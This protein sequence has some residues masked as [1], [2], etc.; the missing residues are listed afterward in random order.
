MTTLKRSV[1]VLLSILMVFS[2]MAAGFTV[3]SAATSTTVYFVDSW[4]WGEVRCYGYNDSASDGTFPGNNMT[5]VDTVDGYDVYSYDVTVYTTISFNNG[6]VYNKTGNLSASDLYGKYYEPSTG[7]TYSSAKEAL[8]AAGLVEGTKFESGSTVY[9]QPAC[10]NSYGAR[11]AA[12]FYNLNGGS[13]WADLTVMSN[14][15]SVYSVT[16]P[17]G[18]WTNVIF[19]RMN[20][21]NGNNTWDNVWNQTANLM[22]D[23]VNNCY[24]ISDWDAG[25][26]KTYTEKVVYF[27][28]AIGWDTVNGYGTTDG[29][30]SNTAW[31]GK[32]ATLVDSEN[33][34]YSFN[35]GDRKKVLFNDNDANGEYTSY[36]TCEDVYGQYIEAKTNAVYETAEEAWAAANALN[37]PSTDVVNFTVGEPLYLIPNSNW[38]NYGTVRFAAYFYNSNG[39]SVWV[40]MDEVDPDTYDYVCDVP[41]G[42]WSNVIFC[43]MDGSTTAN[44]WDNVWNQ[45]ADLACDGVSNCFTMDT[46]SWSDG[47]WGEYV[48]TRCYFVN[49][50]GWAEVGAR[51]YIYC[52]YEQAVTYDA[53]LIDAELGVYYYNPRFYGYLVFNDHDTNGERTAQVNT[54]G[55]QQMYLEPV[56]NYFYNTPEEAWAAAKAALATQETTEATTATE[57]ATEPTTT[58][59]A[60][61]PAETTMSV[62]L[63]GS[64]QT[65]GTEMTETDG[66]YTTTVDIPTGSHTFKIFCNGTA[67]TNANSF[68]DTTSKLDFYTG[69]SNYCTINATGGSYKFTFSK[70]ECWLT[71]EYFPAIYLIGS[72]NDWSLSETPMEVSGVTATASIVLSAGTY[73][74]KV[75][76]NDAWYGNDISLS[77]KTTGAGITLSENT[78]NVVI[79]AS[80]G[81]YTFTY[82]YVSNNLVITYSSGDEGSYKPGE[83]K[84][85]QKPDDSE[86]AVTEPTDDNNKKCNHNYD[87]VKVTKKATYF[88]K[89]KKVYTC[90]ECD[91]TKTVTIKKLKLAKPTVTVKANKNQ[92]KVKYNKV[93]GATGFEV[94]YTVNGKSA[95]KTFTAKKSAL[96]AINKLS[97]GSYKVQVR[98]IATKGNKTATSKWTKATTVKIK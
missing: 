11:F 39:N 53:T 86:V 4:N 17:D 54:S 7:G 49:T 84:P 79:A 14:D 69:I 42:S 34:I 80:G 41:S 83:N 64:W 27:V 26:W 92:I 2:V 82:N 19:C 60:T 13:A 77:N 67:Y 51:N 46:T 93:K 35:P 15:S 75:I 38:I 28:N 10:W 25:Y 89:G 45:T 66:V 37:D 71:V 8:I 58:E 48:D 70:D 36:F 23:E 50:L 1:A 98:A 63:S 21:A 16:V 24:T 44:N 96:K 76:E 94:K 97:K 40:S 59:P 56:T 78:G 91:A 30:G 88:A 81:T 18:D 85:N 87:Q 65:N 47:S 31:P 73:D 61:E 52:N 6:T 32:A 68:D 95:T 20:G 72:F 74:F 33:A 9:L 22:N 29:I 12:Y 43:R 3:T 57:P 5:L 90:S 55:A 62:V